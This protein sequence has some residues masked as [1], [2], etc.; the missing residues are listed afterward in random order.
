MNSTRI[1]YPKVCI[2][3]SIETI[4]LSKTTPFLPKIAKL[5]LIYLQNKSSFN[6]LGL[7]ICINPTRIVINHISS[8]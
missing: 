1:E 4:F 2:T 6:K 5:R 3:V 8:F 7:I